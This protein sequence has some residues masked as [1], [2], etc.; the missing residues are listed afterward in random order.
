M[1]ELNSQEIDQLK[2]TLSKYEKEYD[3]VNYNYTRF[4]KDINLKNASASVRNMQKLSQSVQQECQLQA[5]DLSK[6][7]N[8]AF[9]SEFM[10]TLENH[11]KT[12]TKKLE[13]N[14]E[15]LQANLNTLDIIV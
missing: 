13:Q 4:D 11:L 9:N 12:I 8:I 14:N 3:S 10:V 2:R 1:Y 6:E 15:N 7:M 5:N